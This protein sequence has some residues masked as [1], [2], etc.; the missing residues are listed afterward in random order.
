MTGKRNLT[1]KILMM[2]LAAVMVFTSLAAPQS[3]MTVKADNSAAAGYTL[4]VD[5]SKYNGAIDWK[6]VANGSNIRFAIV[7]AGSTKSG[8]D[9]TFVANMTGASAAGLKTGA[10]IYSYAMNVDQATAEA[11][12]LVKWLAPYTINFPV[13]L[14]I[15]DPSQTGIDANT[16]TAMCN[17]FGDVIK[18]AGY[19]PL[20]Y[21][22]KNFYMAHITTNLKYGL[23]I[24]QHNVAKCDVGSANIWQYTSSGAVAGI[25]TRVD[26]DA[27]MT[28]TFAAKKGNGW[29][30][31]G[32]GTRYRQDSGVDAVGGVCMISGMDYYFDDQGYLIV[33]KPYKINGNLYVFNEYGEMQI[34]RYYTLNGVTYYCDV[35]GIATPQPQTPA[36]QA[37]Q[38]SQAAQAAQ[39]TQPAQ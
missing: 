28:G 18:A 2:M 12:Q 17:A 23:W 13:V 37:A 6:T 11:N 35:R 32:S 16:I 19:T 34:N 10:Y 8:V 14:D 4:G 39:T 24:A 25:S 31:N 22:Y 30:S 36:T 9:P 21:T 20:I 33:S 38:A 26:V 27:L 3:L 5:V 7:K 1:Q 15:E 29:Y